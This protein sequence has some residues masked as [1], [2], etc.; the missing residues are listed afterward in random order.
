MKKENSLSS[1]ETEVAKKTLTKT[2]IF[3]IKTTVK[4]IFFMLKR[5]CN[6]KSMYPF[7]VFFKKGDGVYASVRG[8]TFEKT[9]LTD[10]GAANVNILL[11]R[12]CDMAE[13]ESLSAVIDY[14]SVLINF[15]GGYSYKY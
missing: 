15:S 2:S 14:D 12:M 5:E 9:E 7:K 8:G 13:S 1:S 6:D 3:F 4:Q 11:S 10:K